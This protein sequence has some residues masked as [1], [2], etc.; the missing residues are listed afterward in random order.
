LSVAST[1][2]YTGKLRDAIHAL[3]Y[4]HAPHLAAPLASRLDALL[5]T[6]PYSFDC[7]IPVP[8]HTARLQQR[9]YNQAKL[10]ADQIKNLTGIPVMDSVIVRHQNTRTQVG[11]TAQKRRENVAGAF[12][13]EG[14]LEGKQV[15]LIDDVLT[16]GA[17][18]AACAQT[19]YD[20]GASFVFGLTASHARDLA[21]C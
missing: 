10:L 18:L 8:I 6:L 19:A 14:S 2:L 16:T 17:T 4:N 1:G 3:K 5:A 9:G 11:L 15:L 21:S 13:T 7:L 20:A 12:T